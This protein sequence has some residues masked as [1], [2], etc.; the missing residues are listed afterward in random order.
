MAV[1]LTPFTAL[2]GFRDPGEILAFAEQI[3]ELAEVLGGQTVELLRSG[4]TPERKLGQAY[5]AVFRTCRTRED[6]LPLQRRLLEREVS[7]LSWAEEEFRTLFASFPGERPDQTPS[8]PP[9]VVP[10]RRPGLLRSLP[11]QHLPAAARRGDLPPGGRDPRLHLRGLS[12]GLVLWRQRPLLWSRPPPRRL[13]LPPGVD[14]PRYPGRHRQLLPQLRGQSQGAAGQRQQPLSGSSCGGIQTG[15]DPGNNNETMKQQQWSD[16]A[17][18]TVRCVRAPARPAEPWE[19]RAPSWSWRAAAGFSR[20]TAVRPSSG[21]ARPSWSPPT[22]GWGWRPRRISVSTGLVWATRRLYYWAERLRTRTVMMTNTTDIDSNNNGILI[23][24][25]ISFCFSVL[26]V[27]WTKLS[28]VK[29]WLRLSQT[30]PGTFHC[31]PPTSELW[32]SS[33]TSSHLSPSA[34]S[35]WRPGSRWFGQP[36]I[37]TLYLASTLRAML[38][39]S[40]VVCSILSSALICPAEQRQLPTLHYIVTRHASTTLYYKDKLQP[41]VD[42]RDLL[43]IFMLYLDW[44]PPA[45]HRQWILWRI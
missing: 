33:Q 27:F 24:F 10:P 17:N 29:H 19:R 9:P 34:W 25:I 38:T 41:S 23:F 16:G 11:A 7:D 5:R 36:G 40:R 1:A 42:W 22:S 37:V 2:A 30:S 12:G 3:E 28:K 32:H 13:P 4:E 45:L 21:Q 18:L 39:W 14:R 35:H 20:R 43:V 8:L 15:K 26:D 44:G 6:F 31:P